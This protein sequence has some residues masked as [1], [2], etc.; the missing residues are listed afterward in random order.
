MVTKKWVSSL[1]SSAHCKGLHSRLSSGELDTVI[2]SHFN[3]AKTAEAIGHSEK[4]DAR[5]KIIID[6]D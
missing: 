3:L 4:G 1:F 5:G 6:I 2:G